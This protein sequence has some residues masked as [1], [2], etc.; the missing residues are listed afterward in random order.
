MGVIVAL[1]NYENFSKQNEKIL[2]EL[3]N[4]F[5]KIIIINVINLRINCKPVNIIN[6]KYLPKIFLFVRILTQVVNLLIILKN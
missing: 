4:R 2:K 1:E 3:S 6:E 5:D